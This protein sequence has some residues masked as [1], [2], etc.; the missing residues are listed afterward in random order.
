MAES[1]TEGTLGQFNKAVGDF[2]EVDEELAS[3]ETDKIDVSVNA[4]RG[5][6]ITR[7]LVAEGDAVVV[8]Q[9]IAE[10]GP[11]DADGKADVKQRDEVLEVSEASEKSSSK[12]NFEETTVS[13]APQQSTS[14][15]AATE[16]THS[17][18][19]TQVEQ[20]APL[21]GAPGEQPEGLA[22]TRLSRAE[23]VVSTAYNHYSDLGS[24]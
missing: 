5:G 7:L 23:E 14:S 6:V 4:P 24:Q 18:V 11:G 20:P 16:K 8:D 1:I 9:E 2:I 21:S 3:I 17:S 19:H 12:D 15:T 13:S 22:G 10:I